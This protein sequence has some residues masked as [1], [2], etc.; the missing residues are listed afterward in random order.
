MKPLIHTP[1]RRLLPAVALAAAGLCLTPL[2]VQAGP[3]HSPHSANYHITTGST[4]L[5]HTAVSQAP[6]DNFGF[7]TGG[8][9]Y[10][11]IGDLD[12]WLNR[13]GR[14]YDRYR[15][16]RSQ[17]RYD[18]DD[19]NNWRYR[20]RGYYPNDPDDRNNPRHPDYMGRMSRGYHPYYNRGG[21]YPNDPDDRNNPNHPDY[22]GRSSRGWWR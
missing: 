15:G 20:G 18:P 10:Q 7:A 6:Y 2:A 17:R 19:R 21:Y 1:F 3:G 13:A 14:Y 4:R 22:M 16:Q 8:A 5:P 9:V 12:R 11:P